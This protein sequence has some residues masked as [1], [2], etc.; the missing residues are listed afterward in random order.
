VLLVPE[1]LFETEGFV[2]VI[3]LLPPEYPESVVVAVPV[4]LVIKQYPCSLVAPVGPRRAILFAV[5]V[6]LFTAV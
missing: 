1:V 3:D 5:V 2:N 6:T 4:G